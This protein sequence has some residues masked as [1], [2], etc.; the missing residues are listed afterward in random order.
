[1]FYVKSHSDMWRI[2]KS[3]DLIQNPNNSK[4]L[5]TLRGRNFKTQL[6]ST[7][8]PTAQINPSRKGSFSKT[9]FKPEEFENA[10]FVL[11]WRANTLNTELLE[12]G[13]SR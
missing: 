7:V 11:L 8:G 9:L 6:F 4:A 1:M 10:G 2:L 5:S 13:I 12:N 3:G